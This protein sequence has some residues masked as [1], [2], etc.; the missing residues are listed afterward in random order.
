MHKEVN[1]VDVLDYFTLETIDVVKQK[2]AEKIFKDVPKNRVVEGAVA[3][4]DVPMKNNAPVNLF[5][6][7]RA[8][9]KENSLCIMEITCIIIYTDIPDV[10]LDKY[11][12]HKKQAEKYRN[13]ES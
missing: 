5:F 2:V 3:F 11:N 1:P 8:I 10:V 12:F 9:D 13:N 4:A 6:E 7:Y